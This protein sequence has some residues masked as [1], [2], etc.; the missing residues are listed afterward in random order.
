MRLFFF[1]SVAVGIAAAAADV[2]RQG[3][4]VENDQLDFFC[5][6]FACYF[7]LNFA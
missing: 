2:E 5:V 3:Q 6:C 7:V 4:K 1:S